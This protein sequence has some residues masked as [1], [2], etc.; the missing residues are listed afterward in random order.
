MKLTQKVLL[1]NSTILGIL[2]ISAIIIPKE[3]FGTNSGNFSS[4]ARFKVSLWSMALAAINLNIGIILL[5]LHVV[6]QFF[7]TPPKN[8]S[9]LVAAFLLSAAVAFLLAIP[10]CFSSI[11]FRP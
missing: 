9:S 1:I 2:F 3:F 6:M 11:N 8:Y 10:M 4:L 5:V 7:Q